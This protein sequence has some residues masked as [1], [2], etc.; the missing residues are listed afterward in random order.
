MSAIQQDYNKISP[1]GAL[2]ADGV[3]RYKTRCKIMVDSHN[4][5][6]PEGNSET[7]ILTDDVY[8]VETGK[9]IKG[10]GNAVISLTPSQNYLNLV[11][12][13]DYINIYF[14]IG[15]GAGWTRTFFGFIDRVEETY[16]VGQSGTPTTVYRIVCT[17]FYKAFDKTMIYFNPQMS[18]RPDFEDVDFAAPNIGGLALMSKGIVVGGAPSDIVENVT[19]MLLGFGTQFKLPASYAPGAT[20]DRLRARRVS[21]VR[22]RLPPESVKRLDDAGGYTALRAQAEADATDTVNSALSHTIDYADLYVK[23]AQ[24]YGLANTMDLENKGV[25]DLIKYFTN[26]EMTRVFTPTLENA[27]LAGTA[28]SAANREQSILA[29]AENPKSALIDIIDTFTFIERRAMDGFILGAPVWQQ[30]GSIVSILRAF[31]N[32]AINELFFDLRPLSAD[33]PSGSSVSDYPVSGSY[34]TGPDDKKGNTE[35]KEGARDGINYIASVVM[36]EYPFSTIKQIDLGSATFSIDDKETGTPEVIGVLYYGDI[37]NQGPN[38]PGRH[39]VVGP[40]INLADLNKGKS[41][42]DGQKHLDVAVIEE[43]EITSTSLGR[44]DNDHFNLFEFISDSLLGTDMYWYM[45]DFL[46]IINPIHVT[47]HGLRTRR[48]TTRAA[49]FSLGQLINLRAGTPETAEIDDKK[50][51][52]PNVA[53]LVS[54]VQSPVLAGWSPDVPGSNWNYRVKKPKVGDKFWKWHNGIDINR[55]PGKINGKR[56]RTGGKNIPIHAI[57][58][59]WI[60]VSAPDG[61]VG[62]YGNHIV[63][64]HNFAAAGIDGPR[65]SVYGHLS[66]RKVKW[67][68]KVPGASQGMRPNYFAKGMTG[69][70][71][72][73]NTP[74]KINKGDIIGWMGHSG[75]TT[76]GDHLHF[77]IDNF[78]PPY[79]RMSNKRNVTGGKTPDRKIIGSGL[80]APDPEDDMI[81]SGK[82]MASGQ[83]SCDPNEFYKLFGEDLY[84]LINENQPDE[85]EGSEDEEDM[86]DNG[87][88]DSDL[89]KSMED[90]GVEDPIEEIKAQSDKSVSRDSVDTASIRKQIS[91]W[92]L[93]QDHWYQHNIEYLSG[94]VDMRGAPEIRVGYR[95]DIEDRNM[96]FYVEGVNHSWQFPNS[97]KTSLQVSRG[98]PNNP[99]P[100]YVLPAFEP[101]GA[102]KG[103]RRASTSRLGTFFITPDPVAIRRSLFL[104]PG[105]R[106][107][108]PGSYSGLQV[109]GST[110][111][112]EV[113]YIDPDGWDGNIALKFDEAVIPAGATERVEEP[114]TEPSDP[115][116]KG[117]NTTTK[118]E[119][120]GA[121]FSRE[122]A[123]RRRNLKGRRR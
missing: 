108:D 85:D 91:R 84:D 30:Q 26:R 69:V 17:D 8:A 119:N 7:I 47:R 22:G 42:G 50:D 55:K 67:G 117:S 44:S 116:D 68:A 25:E 87:V 100:L 121:A 81:A 82:T 5:A 9:T 72:G 86:L 24:K 12:P 64:K 90:E 76:S 4:S 80:D 73:L 1:T 111:R 52:L 102:T 21:G 54:P 71:R 34:S 46:P 97:M 99:F 96:S 29:S 112:N 104:T 89:N 93:L 19:L 78:F 77:E 32:E 15:D 51:I 105:G 113:D 61:V 38:V 11:F 40:N 53:S 43:V 23:L 95:L 79:P 118:G 37:F 31:S 110:G 33:D 6:S 18:G 49:R 103:Q 59:G 2:G 120:I 45:K 27:S 62:G 20:Q 115:T 83:H 92:A 48:V 123:Q 63:I 109:T 10:G 56:N 41:T 98:Q 66:E 60:V 94:R 28:A 107:A 13:D 114:I 3:R 70:S 16:S 65:Y 35:D 39:V 122:D 88:Y 57:A 14:D 101:M 74:H 58:D 75:T 106:D 36:R